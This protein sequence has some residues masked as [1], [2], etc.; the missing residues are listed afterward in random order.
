MQDR[1]TNI[2]SQQ[3]KLISENFCELFNLFLKLYPALDKKLAFVV[4]K[5]YISSLSQ[6]RRTSKLSSGQQ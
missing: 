2:L 5:G 3:T 4:K 6:R 1:I